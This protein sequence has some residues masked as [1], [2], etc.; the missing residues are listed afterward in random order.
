[1][2][3]TI[4]L[5]VLLVIVA[6]PFALDWDYSHRHKPALEAEAEALLAQQGLSNIDVELNYF[7]AVLTGLVQ[8][9]DARKRAGDIVK[10]VRPLRVADWENKIRITPKLTAEIK[11]NTINLAGWLP[12]AEVRAELILGVKAFRPELKINSDALDVSP[13]VESGEIVKFGAS[14]ISKLVADVLNT[15]R[16]PPSLKIQRSGQEYRLSGH[17]K[18]EEL[19]DSIAQAAQNNPG[20]W[21]VNI[22]ALAANKNVNEASFSSGTALADFVRSFF[23][24]PSPGE[25]SID[26]RNGPFI[27]AYATA[28]MEAEWLSLLR[29]ITGAAKLRSEITRVPSAYHFPDYKITSTI[30]PD[31]VPVLKAALTKATVRFDFGSS[32]LKP[33]ELPKLEP[34]LPLLASTG[35]EARFILAA[36][37]D[38]AGGEPGSETQAIQKARAVAVQKHLTERGVNVSQLEMMVFDRL[39]PPGALTEDVRFDCRKVELLIK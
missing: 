12:S 22:E 38:P 8:T 5:L 1:M 14:K 7:D 31:L 18:T 3:F 20:G 11:G 25:F 23:K 10:T 9:P 27:K 29:P 30:A 34:L 6:T 2:R 37:A 19:L 33:D 17:V 32:D 26:L 28:A 16:V 4:L 36:Y 24:S 39:S 13:R 15:I 35:P 21:K